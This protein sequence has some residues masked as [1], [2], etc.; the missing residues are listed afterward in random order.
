MGGKAWE[1]RAEGESLPNTGEGRPWDSRC[2]EM[3]A[4]QYPNITS[5]QHTKDDNF[6]FLSNNS[7]MHHIGRRICNNS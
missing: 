5:T 2:L 1:S 7:L 4:M 6:G 3:L